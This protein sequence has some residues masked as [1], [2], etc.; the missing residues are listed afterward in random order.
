M[1][2]LNIDGKRIKVGDEFMQLSPEEQQATVEQIA[3]QLGQQPQKVPQEQRP[4]MGEMGRGNIALGIGENA[5][6]SLTGA[7]DAATAGLRGIAAMVPGGKSPADAVNESLGKWTYEPR[8]TAG[9]AIGGALNTV[10]QKM[11]QAAHTVG[12]V[13]GDDSDALGATLVKTALLGAP[14]LLGFRGGPKKG[15]TKTPTA[16]ELKTQAKQA[17]K[18]AEDS[19]VIISKDSYGPAA[20]KIR[21]RMADEGIDKG[22]HKKSMRAL[23]RILQDSDKHL[24]L[25]GAE[26][27]RQNINDAI[28]A[29]KSKGDRRLAT[30]MKREF[31]DYI[32]K[33][34]GKDVL[35]GDAPQAT[36]TLSKARDLYTKKSKAET[37]DGLVKRAEIRS[38]QFS[39]SGYENAL[40]TE[41]RNF[42]MNEKKM[43]GFT[44]AEQAAIRQV[45]EG[46]PVANAL[47]FFGKLAPTGVV[48]G[49]LGGGIGASVGGPI[50]AMA[51]PLLG[52]ASRKAATTATSRN[53]LRASELMRRGEPLPVR[54]TDKRRAATAALLANDPQ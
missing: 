29:A 15:P 45:A 11:D 48:S 51:V 50:G 3:S 23:K 26:R 53:A 34:E 44:K 46:G 30:I 52:A 36:A 4:L 9:Q 32:T 7:A 40:R 43:R 25:K 33:L 54:K 16:S 14:M 13:S 2:T 31:D 47:R 49:A 17:Y 22:L 42:A 20:E 5:L 35:A 6:S 38:S 12:A 39:G 18:E 1:P 27:I 19:G 10:G 24:T 41:F 28:D 21:A 8:T 37:I